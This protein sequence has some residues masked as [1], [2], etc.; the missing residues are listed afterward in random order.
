MKIAKGIIYLIISLWV[1]AILLSI[2]SCNPV[3]KVLKDPEKFDIVKEEVL[4]RGYCANDTTIVTKSDTLVTIDTVNNYYIDTEI[5]NDT[6]YKTKNIRSIATKIITIRDT[7][8][9][10]IV[11]NSRIKILQA[12]L[13]NINDELI[14][15]KEKA[16]VR[17]K[18]L[19]L[20]SVAIAAYIWLKIKK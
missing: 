8:K 9:G 20:L 17:L 6:V 3:R 5:R 12:D 2:L 18:W 19:L 4:R 7:I 11:D 1:L 16:K 13:D 15:Y 10:F 14:Q